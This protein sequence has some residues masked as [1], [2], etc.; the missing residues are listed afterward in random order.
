MVRNVALEKLLR[1]LEIGEV[2]Y[3]TA[4]AWFPGELL[5]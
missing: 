3:E 1:Q 2:D 5:K 4:L